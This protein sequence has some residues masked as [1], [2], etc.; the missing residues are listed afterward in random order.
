[1]PT[2][3]PRSFRVSKHFFVKPPAPPCDMPEPVPLASDQK[4]ERTDRPENQPR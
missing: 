4:P 1:M 3:N 2:I